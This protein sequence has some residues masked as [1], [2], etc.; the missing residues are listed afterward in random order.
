VKTKTEGQLIENS[1]DD[2]VDRIHENYRANK[3]LK[4]AKMGGDGI[5][6]SGS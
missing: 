2:C 1:E 5:H 6:N 4:T 3:G